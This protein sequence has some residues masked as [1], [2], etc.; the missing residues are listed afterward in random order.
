MSAAKPIAL[1]SID[2]YLAGECTAQHKHEYAAGRV[3]MMAG[4][5]NEHNSLATSIT[6]ALGAQL[7]GK[8]C[9][10]FNSDTKVRV[11]LAT[12]TRFYYPDVMVVC[13]ANPPGDLFQDSPV[14]IVEVVSSSTRRIDQGEKRD[15]YL[16]IQTLKNYLMVEST[17]ARV[18]ACERTRDGGFIERMYEGMDAVIPLD[19]IGASL[20]FAEIYERVVFVPDQMP[21][22][23]DHP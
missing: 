3:Y 14:V 18:F 4:A 21:G 13:A 17:S 2:D 7:R 12:Q 1:I 23:C 10:P 16:T 8:K 19:A 11:Q 15:A 6:V 20:S 9:Q 22:D 5:S